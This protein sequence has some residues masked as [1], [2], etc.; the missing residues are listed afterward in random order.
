MTPLQRRIALSA[1]IAVVVG[2][3]WYLQSQKASPAPTSSFPLRTGGSA[4]SAPDISTP[5]GFINTSGIA[6]ADLI[7]KKVVL[8]DFWTYSCINCQR[9]TPYLNAW[10]EKYKDQGLE[11]IGIH[12][13]EFEFEKKIDNVREAV[14]Q[15]GI[16]FPVVLDND[17]STWTSYGNRYWPRKYLIDIHGHVV[18]D[19]IGEGAYEE[20]ERRIQEALA[21]RSSVLGQ[22]LE[23]TS[24]IAKPSDAITDMLA[25]RSPEVYF[26]AFRND[27]LGNGQSGKVIETVFVL[28]E[29]VKDNMFYLD[30]GWSVQQEYAEN[31]QAGS[32][33]IFRYRAMNVYMVAASEGGA[34][35]RVMRDGQPLEQSLSGADVRDGALYVQEE[36]LYH[37]ISEPN[38]GEHLL[39]LI[40]DEPGLQAFTF[41]FG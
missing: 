21:E 30:G 5:D 40:V 33:L 38:G 28:P 15:F 7:G 20:T 32:K 36:R 27:A 19:H 23:I 3:I 13:P 22:T 37:L 18:Y 41:T 12:T 10:Y 35:V 31:L 25:S 29:T 2:S 17:F 24:E 14:S 39:E 6:L 1:V 4:A 8:I 34:T 9:T 26:G 11:I 16:K